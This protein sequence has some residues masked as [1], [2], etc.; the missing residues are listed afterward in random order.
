MVSEGHIVHYWYTS[1]VMVC[2]SR[3]IKFSF[4]SHGPAWCFSTLAGCS[5]IKINL[6]FSFYP[7]EPCRNYYSKELEC[8]P[9]TGHELCSMEPI[10][11][12]FLDWTSSSKNLRLTLGLAWRSVYSSCVS[13]GSL[14]PDSDR[15]HKKWLLWLLA[16]NHSLYSPS[17]ASWFPWRTN[18]EGPWY[19]KLDYSLYV[20][21]VIKYLLYTRH[22]LTY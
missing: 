13:A 9:C 22:C 11:S 16:I 10:V 19:L 14:I 12:I 21:S 5:K 15:N 17:F 2:D 6:C 18:V 1:T 20:H 7:S 4:S 3:R 8:H